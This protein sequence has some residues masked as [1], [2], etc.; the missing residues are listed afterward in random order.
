MR[1]VFV[2][3]H[4]RTIGKIV[5]WR[6]ILTFANFSYTYAV[7]GDWQAGLTVA[8]IA[9]IFNTMIYWSHERV[10]NIFSWGKK[11]KVD[12]TETVVYK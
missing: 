3:T 12:E 7:T 6:I 9:A 10:W 1:E 4:K 5:S 8:G 2:E 11:I